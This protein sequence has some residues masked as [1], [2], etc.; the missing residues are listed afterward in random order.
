MRAAEEE[1]EQ[2]TLPWLMEAVA[3]GQRIGAVRTD[4]PDELLIALALGMGQAMDTWLITRR[5]GERDLADAV[6]ALI[7]MMRRAFQP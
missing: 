5:S 4:L 6:H 3:A 7:D 1:A 2:A